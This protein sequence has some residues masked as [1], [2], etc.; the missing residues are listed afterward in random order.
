MTNK[1][2]EKT[3]G[4]LF[5][6]EKTKDE[7]IMVSFIVIA[8]TIFLIL[9]IHYDILFN[10]SE[11]FNIKY[12][13]NIFKLFFLFILPIVAFFRIIYHLFNS[14][15]GVNFLNKNLRIIGIIF[16]SCFAIFAI[17]TIYQ[18]NTFDKYKDKLIQLSYNHESG[19]L[20]P[21]GECVDDPL[22]K[23]LGFE[24]KN[25]LECNLD[26]ILNKIDNNVFSFLLKE[27]ERTKL[28]DKIIAKNNKDKNN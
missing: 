15:S 1:K 16:S 11:T 17:F 6:I 2:R 21:I 10:N 18:I 24:K 26:F 3:D 28:V 20:P 23:V 9:P 22:K 5:G 13:D 8:I 4:G 14:E 19:L 7:R 27:D 12:D 25:N